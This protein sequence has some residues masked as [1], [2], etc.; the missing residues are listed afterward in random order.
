ME[1][2]VGDRVLGTVRPDAKGEFAL[3]LPVVPETY[4]GT[5]TV[6]AKAGDRTASDKVVVSSHLVPLA[7]QL[8]SSTLSLVGVDSEETAGEQAGGANAID[9]DPATFW[10]TQ[11][12]GGSPAYPHW[13]TID[14]GAEYEVT[15]F[16]YTQ[17]AGQANGRMKDYEVYVGDSPDEF[18]DAVQTGSFLDIGR[19][20]VFEFD[21]PARGR[22]LKLVGTSSINGNAFGG[23]AEI[24]VGAVTPT[25]DTTR[26]TVSLV[27]PT[28]AGPFQALQIEMD[29]AD[30]G[31]LKRIV[32]NIYK[33]STLVKS[34]QTQVGG[35]TTGHHAATVKL[36]DGDYTI[37]YNAQ[38]LAGN[39][40]A[41]RTF[42]VTVDAT[43]P[44]ATVKDGAQFT[45]GADGVYDRVSFKLHDAGKIDKVT[46]NG[47][48]KDLSNNT[49][50]D[51][52][53]I[54]PGTFGAVKGENTLVVFDV[55]GN[56]S[57]T[58]FT[59]S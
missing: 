55:A 3:S 14:L 8:D 31:G 1:L 36:P 46:L 10:H 25:A 56:T 50:S 40:S 27:S 57:T 15:G 26:P 29:A 58:T 18:G 11:W 49:W 2:S 28:A 51:V 33:G 39:I 30:A 22:Y 6:T 19:E 42:A 48:T 37:R 21:T 9:G 43:A 17:R 47:V 59:L 24:A 23:A 44:T 4:S 5:Y 12:Q 13:I 45:V 34:T 52:N 35:A 38:D 7:N 54:K 53:G 41:T 16:A 32:A 20:Q